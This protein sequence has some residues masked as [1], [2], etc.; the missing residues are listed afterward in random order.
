[1][2]QHVKHYV[3]PAY[4]WCLVSSIT[5]KYILRTRIQRTIFVVRAP[6]CAHKSPMLKSGPVYTFFFNSIPTSYRKMTNAT[7][8]TLTRLASI[9]EAAMFDQGV[10]AFATVCVQSCGLMIQLVYTGEP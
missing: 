10:F 4:S 1:M 9:T 2:V 6:R 3:T 5:K 7:L 8:R